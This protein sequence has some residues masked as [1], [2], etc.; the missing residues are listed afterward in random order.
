MSDIVQRL[1]AEL[2]STRKAALRGMDAAHSLSY[3]QLQAA[4]RIRGES[5]PDALES[6]RAANARLTEENEQLRADAER[7]RWLRHGDN[8]EKIIKVYGADGTRD[9]DA[10]FDDCWLPRNE[11]LDAAI[12]AQRAGEKG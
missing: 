9:F 7:Y 2:E 10:S 6:E 8:D 1:R 11:Q 5:S 4:Q 3:A 12:D